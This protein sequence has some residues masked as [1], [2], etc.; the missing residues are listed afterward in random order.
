MIIL[1]SIAAWFTGI[2]FLVVFFPFTF[3]IWLLALPFDRKRRV[4]HALL[5]WQST[6][7]TFLMPV[8]KVNISGKEKIN[9]KGTYVIIANHQSLLDILVVNCLRLRFKWVSKAENNKVPFLGWYLVMA[10]Y[11]TVDRQNDESKSL[12]LARAYSCL[13]E[14]TSVMIF[15]EG[16]RS[17]DGSIGYFRRGAFQLALETGLPV[18]PLVIDGTGGVLPK[19]RL[20]FKGDNRITLN[21]MEPV[22]PSSFGTNDPMELAEKFRK[23]ITSELTNMRSGNAAHS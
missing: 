1:R 14:G 8:W 9:R 16:T 4:I 23:L 3:I 5:V 22:F 19:H 21:V 10:N 11:L 13:K 18:L 6:F 7:I 20:I 15:P 17:T 2:T 12:M